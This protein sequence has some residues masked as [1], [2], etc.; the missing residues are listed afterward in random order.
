[1]HHEFGRFD[2]RQFFIESLSSVV[3]GSGGKGMSYL[4][5]SRVL[6]RLGVRSWI[7]AKNW[8]TAIGG[9]WIDDGV[10]DAMN[11]VAKVFV[12]MRELLARAD[13]RIAHYSSH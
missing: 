3:D 4:Y 13:E 12:D 9:N 2:E 10:L 11:E 8:S 7:N 5:R 1:L 6:E